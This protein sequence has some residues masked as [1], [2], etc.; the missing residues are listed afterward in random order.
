VKSR[1]A[2]AAPMTFAAVPRAFRAT[3][4]GAAMLVASLLPVPMPAL[5]ANAVEEVVSPGG[6]RAW[7]VTDHTVPLVSMDFAFRGGASQDP[8]GKPGVANL[9]ST[10]LDEGAG[11]LDSAAF[12]RRLDETAVRM[13]FSAGYDAFE[14]SFSS[15]SSRLKDGVGLLALALSAPRFDPDPIERMR[16]SLVS[17]LRSQESD[18]DT[19]AG[20]LFREATFPDHPYGRPDEGTPE[21]LAAIGR[22]DVVAFHHAKLA[23]D[24]L[25]IGVVGDVTAAE[26][27]PLLD[28]AF[29][30]LPAAAELTPV[31]DVAPKTGLTLSAAVDEPQ[32]VIRFATPG[33]LRADPDFM[34]AY[35]MNHI[36]GGGTFSSR[37]YTEVREK[38]GLAYNVFSAVIPYEHAGLFLA[39]TA[40]RADKAAESVAVMRGELE[41]MAAEGPTEAELAAAR[42]YLVGNYAL[43]FDSSAKISGQLVGL[44]LDRLP[45][46]YFETRNALVEAVTLDDV[47]RVAKRILSGPTTVLTVGPGAG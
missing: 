10:L 23:R 7:L 40:T 3:L 5:A 15:L 31:P 6:I 39:G 4:A 43:R 26:L 13:S 46:D 27:A 17:G 25:V 2:E 42:T 21:T 12:Q 20:R 44:Q 38:R 35:V 24:N 30:A 41:R 37:L 36:L 33:L 16:A 28:E 47:R 34:A 14:G 22:D 9:L 19:I 18:P 11:D 32:T 1:N 45:I 29:G 8:P